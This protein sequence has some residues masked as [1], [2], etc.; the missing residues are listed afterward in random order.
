[1]SKD[2]TLENCI[3]DLALI[4]SDLGR[5]YKKGENP[6]LLSAFKKIRAAL[7]LLEAAED[8]LSGIK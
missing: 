2:Q 1:M 5:L 4:K 3:D 6:G 8:E 7:I